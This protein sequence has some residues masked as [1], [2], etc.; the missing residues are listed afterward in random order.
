[1]G[2]KERAEAQR[3]YTARLREEGYQMRSVWVHEGDLDLWDE[4]R[5]QFRKRMADRSSNP[6]SVTS[7]RS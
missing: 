3:A 5:E 4:V 2:R 6:S 7:S 1:M